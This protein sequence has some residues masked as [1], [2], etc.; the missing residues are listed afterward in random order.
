[1]CTLVRP[2]HGED[3]LEPQSSGPSEEKTIQKRTG[4]SVVWR[5]WRNRPG[6]SFCHHHANREDVTP[7]IRLS[8]IHLFRRHVAGSPEERSE[9]GQAARLGVGRLQGLCDAEIH[10]LDDVA[11]AVL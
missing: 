6:Q 1:M 9:L 7:G 2:T 11:A 4:F 3:T 8:S 5:I 10:Q